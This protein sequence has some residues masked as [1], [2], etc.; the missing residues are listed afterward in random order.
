VA[1]WSV[2]GH[3][4]GLWGCGVEDACAVSDGDQDAGPAFRP[5]PAA[6]GALAVRAALVSGQE[7][8]RSAGLC[9]HEPG[10][11]LDRVIRR[12]PSGV[13]RRFDGGGVHHDRH[14]RGSNRA[15]PRRR[16][17]SWRSDSAQRR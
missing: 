5:V 1:G 10:G 16:C 8:F 17:C 14:L 15:G 13:F 6:A 4:S 9:G 2:T 12:G 11:S 3:P 7:S